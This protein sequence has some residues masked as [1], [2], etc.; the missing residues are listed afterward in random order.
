MKVGRV[1]GCL[2]ILVVLIGADLSVR[3]V[4]SGP[5][6][7]VLRRISPEFQADFGG[8]MDVANYYEELV[9]EERSARGGL[10]TSHWLI[11]GRNFLAAEKRLLDARS[12]FPFVD[13]EYGPNRRV[14]SP[15]G[16]VRTN[17]L[18]MVD[19]EYAVEKPADTRRILFFGDSLGRALGVPQE[20][21]IEPQFEEWLNTAAINPTGRRVEILNFST[22][23]HRVIRSLDFAI[24]K[25]PRLSPDLFVLE[26]SRRDLPPGW[27]SDI[28]HFAS[29]G[30]DPPHPFIRD[31]IQRAGVA[32]DDSRQT[33]LAK[34]DSIFVP[35]M[36]LVLEEFKKI[37]A[38]QRVEA[39]V[40]LLPTVEHPRIQ[41]PRFDP[42]R[43]ILKDLNYPVLDL[44]DAFRDV[45]DPGRLGINVGDPHPNE[46]GHAIL[47]ARLRER[48]ANQPAILTSL[49]GQTPAIRKP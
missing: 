46:E 30:L 21:G 19:R 14:S 32:G 35:G 17:S 20:K 16:P 43:S 1:A 13:P 26:M 4:P 3:A 24:R 25:A 49:L 34:F 15:A 12:A 42:L 36:R 47:F 44:V 45:P 18:G 7:S 28:V 8:E 22:S 37:A 5:L 2:A 39:V 6:R 11:S 38:A 10:L 27:A 48:L 29:K 23:G 41:S 31:L 33:A 40:L 9:N